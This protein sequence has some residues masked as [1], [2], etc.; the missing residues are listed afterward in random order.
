MYRA[1]RGYLHRVRNVARSG[2]VDVEELRIV[3]RL[4]QLLQLGA[5]K[6][7]RSLCVLFGHCA[8]P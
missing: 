3:D 6:R 5:S 2:C 8:A 4:P 7:R 1:I